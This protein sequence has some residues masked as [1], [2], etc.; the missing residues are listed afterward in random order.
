MSFQIA[1]MSQLQEQQQ[2]RESALHYLLS[3]FESVQ[4]LV[5]KSLEASAPDQLQ[6]IVHQ[7]VANFSL[8]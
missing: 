2:Q 6:A 1:V 8:Q 3:S 4:S 7:E 5:G